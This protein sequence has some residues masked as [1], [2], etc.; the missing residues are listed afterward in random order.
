MEVIYDRIQELEEI[1]GLSKHEQ[2][3]SGIINAINDK[4]LARGTMLPSVN[5]MVKELGFASKTIVKAYSELKDRGLIASKKRVGYFVVNDSTEQTVKLALLIYAFHPFQEVF[6]NTFRATLGENIQVD[7]FFHHSNMEV[8]ET[9]LDNINGRY[10]MYVVAPIPDPSTKRVLDK[11]PRERLLLVDRYEALD[12]MF[13]HVTQEF[14]LSTYI[15]LKELA[16]SIQNYDE[17]VLY[18][19]PNTD[20]PAEV[21]RAFEH[22]VKEY[23]IAG[24][25]ERHYIPGSIKKGVVYFTIGDSDLWGILKDAKARGWVVGKDFG[26]F[27]NNDGPV[28]E[29]VCDG[30]TTLSTD[31]AKMG[32]RAAEYVLSRETMQE[33][34]PTVLIRRGSV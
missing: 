9:I 10:G 15:A 6:Y 3:V 29:I 13:S 31:F 26:V 25:V 4:V 22:F 17:L 16:P 18:F 34:I 24:R 21:K 19:L 12:G 27:S 23:N 2:L 20:Y 1:S 11:L 7:V 28:K 32:Q 5:E 14:E 8:F 33:T 30:I